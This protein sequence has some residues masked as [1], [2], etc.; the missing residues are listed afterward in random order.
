VKLFTHVILA[1]FGCYALIGH[2][3]IETPLTLFV[4]VN[5]DGGAHRASDLERTD[6]PRTCVYI[7]VQLAAHLASALSHRFG[8]R[9]C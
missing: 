9:R 2:G 7:G 3:W 8:G 5:A 6:F 4:D 1:L